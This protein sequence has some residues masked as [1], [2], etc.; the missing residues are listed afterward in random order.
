MKYTKL[1][2]SILY[3]ILFIFNTRTYLIVFF[4]IVDKTLQVLVTHQ[5]KETATVLLN[6]SDYKLRFFHWFS[7]GSEAIA[8][9]TLYCSGS[10]CLKLHL[11][12][13]FNRI[14][15]YRTKSIR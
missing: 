7:I 4:R 6:I 11:Y 3:Y 1:I 15:I 12:L 13:E 10:E 14:K 8:H 5:T 2:Y 9:W